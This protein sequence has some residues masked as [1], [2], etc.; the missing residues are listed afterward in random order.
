[1]A[2]QQSAAGHARATGT[3]GWLAVGVLSVSG[4]SIFIRLADA[5]S[6]A[7]AALRMLIASAVV[8]GGALLLARDGLRRLTR[9]DVKWLAVSGLF[10]AA[11][12]AA[13][14]TSLDYTSVA[15]SVLL[16]TTTPIFTAV[17]SVVFLR[18]RVSGAMAVAIALTMAGGFLLAL[19]N[20][21]GERHLLGDALALLG[22]VAVAGYWMVGRKVR[23]HIGILPYVAVVYPVAALTLLAVAM[24][25]Q[26]PIAGLPAS[27]Y[28]WIALAAL[29]PQVVG[30]SLLNW[31]LAHVPPIVVTI[32]VRG[33]TVV[34]TLLAIPIL[35]EVPG[36]TVVPGGALLLAGALL[37]IRDE[38][39]TG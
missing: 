35:G 3:Y 2:K 26:T 6:L 25:F 11:H 18:E 23:G 8:A 16:V 27:A 29:L 22:A 17:G 28:G 12:F 38:R 7:I 30:H 33:E 36:W 31:S 4:A 37:A 24:M 5:P 13:W 9:D 14:I 32:A 10:L 1:M 34:A 15:S 39:A 20:S 21:G 19:D